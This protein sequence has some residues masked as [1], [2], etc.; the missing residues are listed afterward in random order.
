MLPRKVCGCVDCTTRPLFSF[1]QP[2]PFA[3]SFFRKA[4]NAYMIYSQENRDRVKKDNPDAKMG[5]I[6]KL[7]GEA[8]KKLGSEEKFELDKKV[9]VFL[10]EG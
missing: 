1:L 8:Y 7:L 9:C 3:C 10:D 6:A 5:E 4:L 2:F